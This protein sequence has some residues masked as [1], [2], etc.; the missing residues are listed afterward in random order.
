MVISLCSEVVP[1]VYQGRDRCDHRS[2]FTLYTGRRLSFQFTVSVASA[3]SPGIS[4][5]FEVMN[6][7]IDL[8]KWKE[9]LMGTLVFLL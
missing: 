2:G 4:K 5:R 8:R 6:I 7:M 3:D 9:T 1:T